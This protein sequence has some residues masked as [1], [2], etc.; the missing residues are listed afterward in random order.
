MSAAAFGDAAAASSGDPFPAGAPLPAL[1]IL[2]DPACVRHRPGPGHPES[3]ERYG[4]VMGAL[5]EAGLLLDAA[6]LPGRGASRD[7]L[8][9]VHRPAYL[10]KAEAE[11]RDG[12]AE[13]STGDVQV[14]PESW[15]T[16]LWAAGTAL[17]GV[18]AVLDGQARRAFC[19]LR[20]PGHHATADRGMGFCI[21]NNVALAARHAQARHGL[22]RALIIDWDLHHGNGTQDIFYE[23]GSV[24]YFSTH[25]SPL[26]PGTGLA[27]ETG[28]GPGLG[29]TLNVPLRAGSGRAEVMAAF[30]Q[31]LLPAAEAFRPELVLIS[32]GFDARAGD[33]LGD[34]RLTDEDFY[35]LTRLVCGIADRHAG[36]RVVSVLEGGYNLAGLGL[37]AAAHVRGLLS[38]A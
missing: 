9:R 25:Q 8:E 2:H 34:L 29:T 35:D 17:A 19:V 11:I 28:R 12:A 23:D 36:G 1:A 4:A 30:Q 6:V 3:P 37:A 32:A 24:F 15:E 20:P 5:T 14:C 16:A 18:E 22:R 10:D 13:L 27:H 33:P 38:P 31:G 7:E 21:L 26:Y